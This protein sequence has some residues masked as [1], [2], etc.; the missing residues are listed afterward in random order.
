ML[1]V[2]PSRVRASGPDAEGD[3]QMPRALWASTYGMDKGSLLDQ[4]YDKLLGYGLKLHQID[5]VCKRHAEGKSFEDISKE[6]GWTTGSSAAYHCR[7]ALKELR[8][9]GFK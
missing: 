7:M 1:A 5:L 2:D 9:R 3:Y 8:E 6:S 4:L